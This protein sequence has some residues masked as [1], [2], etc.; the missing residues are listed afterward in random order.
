MS[1]WGT[2]DVEH[3]VDLEEFAVVMDDVHSLWIEVNAAFLIADEGGIG[4]AVPKGAHCVDELAGTLVAQGVRRHG[5]VAEVA[6]GVVISRCDHVP[7]NSPAG[8]MVE[9]G[10]LPRHVVGL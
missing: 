9:R 10:E 6:R 8:N 5:H 2:L 3:S 7:S 4:P 1:L